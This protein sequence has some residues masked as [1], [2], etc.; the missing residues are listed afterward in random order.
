[1]EVNAGL[2]EQIKL[3][4]DENAIL[5]RHLNEP[6]PIP[7]YHSSPI[8]SENYGNISYAKVSDINKPM[9]KVMRYYTQAASKEPV[10]PTQVISATAPLKAS[11]LSPK[12]DFSPLKVVFFKGCHRKNIGTYKSMLP[13]IG[14]EPHWARHIVFLA[15][16]LLQIT[17]F[18]CKVDLLIKSMTSISPKVTHLPNFDPF[19]GASYADYGVF[20]DESASKSYLSVIKQCASKLQD[21]CKRTPSLRR[22][23][24]FL[25]KLVETKT[26]NLE[27]TP[28]ASR[29]FCLGDYIVKKVPAATA[30]DIETSTVK[31][32]LENID[33]E[34]ENLPP[35]VQTHNGKLSEA[36]PDSIMK[37][38]SP[39]DN[40]Q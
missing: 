15:E 28:R 31:C 12:A 34:D 25:M 29:V 20:T 19:A 21:D 11:S 4:K 14:F 18:E 40:D 30:M 38:T 2:A 32:P 23:A 16:D 27:P 10:S 1:M 7:K 26:I 35:G 24:F 6:K 3:L 8:K 22:I 13:T 39:L 9:N 37:E 5:K 33:P 17:T 36:D